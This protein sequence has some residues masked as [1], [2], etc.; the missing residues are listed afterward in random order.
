M[1]RANLNAASVGMQDLTKHRFHYPT[2]PMDASGRIQPEC[3]FGAF[4]PSSS[5]PLAT[6]L[7]RNFVPPP[8]VVIVSDI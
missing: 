7:L 4:S 2:T 6:G 1:L 5:F 3:L 8:K